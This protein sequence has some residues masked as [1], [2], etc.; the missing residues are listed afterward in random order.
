MIK[1]DFM[2]LFQV[3]GK[4]TELNRIAGY[5]NRPDGYFVVECNIIEDLNI[6]NIKYIDILFL[7]AQKLAESL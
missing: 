4:S 1:T 6:N 7:A 5:L 3:C 2:M